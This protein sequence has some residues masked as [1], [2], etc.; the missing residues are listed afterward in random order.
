MKRGQKAPAERNPPRAA[1]SSQATART[2]R[3]QAGWLADGSR[4]DRALPE[5]AAAP[6]RPRLARSS[7]A[8]TGRSARRCLCWDWSGWWCWGP[9]T[10]PAPP[11]ALCAREQVEFVVVTAVRSGPGVESSAAPVRG[12]SRILPWT[13]ERGGSEQGAQLATAARSLAR[14]QSLADG[15][16]RA[17]TVAAAR[18]VE[19]RASAVYFRALRGRINP[20]YGFRGRNRR[21][22][23]DPANA[24]LS[25]AY[26]LI[27]AEA[28]AAVCPVGWSPRARV[29]PSCAGRP[30]RPGA[31]L[32]GGVPRTGGRCAPPAVDR[33][34]GAPA[35][36]LLRDGPRH[37][38]ERK[39]AA[40]PASGGHEAKMT[41]PFQSL[42]GAQ[43]TLREAVRSQARRLADSIRTGEPY[44][45]L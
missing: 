26:T 8:T 20:E 21:P 3:R 43:T 13:G 4:I 28:A 33:P 19:G 45:P 17:G 16:G 35:R 39:R 31:G 7:F 23:R 1:H 18:G 44:A 9:R 29:L 22:P 32:G 2:R 41:Q 24:I 42:A 5:R 27:A 10:L 11:A 37:A 30:A 25:F 15:A 36:E 34:A 12:Q 40:P 6:S 14:A 38:N